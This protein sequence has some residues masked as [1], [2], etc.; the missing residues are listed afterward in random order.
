MIRFAITFLESFGG[1]LGLLGSIGLLPFCGWRPWAD[2][3]DANQ[4][5]NLLWA[6]SG[7][8]VASASCLPMVR[9]LASMQALACILGS[10]AASAFNSLVG[11]RGPM[12]TMRI[13]HAS[14]RPHRQPASRRLEAWGR[15][16]WASLGTQ[17]PGSILGL[18]LHRPLAAVV[19]GP[20]P[21]KTTSRHVLKE[22][23]F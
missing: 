4:A 16:A 9:G 21:M 14:S 23:L 13:R 10:F 20:R 15:W 17:V 1:I 7:S 2:E 22:T 18:I 6:S 3:H 5:C 19:G 8:S 11:G 12:R